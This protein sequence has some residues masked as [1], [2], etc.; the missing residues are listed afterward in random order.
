[1]KKLVISISIATALSSALNAQNQVDA[2]RY[3]QT[4]YGGTA[5]YVGMGGAFGALGADAS[6][7][8]SNPAGIGMY[9]KSELT[10]TPTL[11]NGS[12]STNYNGSS[13]KDNK[14]NF[15]FGNAAFIINVPKAK[16]DGN[17]EWKSF[18]FGIAYNRQ[19]NFHNRNFISGNA[20]GSSLLN[21][22]V[23]ESDGNNPNNLNQFGNDLAYQTYLID[24]IP[25]EN[26]LYFSNTNF[27]KSSHKKS[28]ET[29]GSMGET[30]LA[31]GANYNNK[32][33]LGASL[34]FTKIKYEEISRY[35]ESDNDT[36]KTGTYLPLYKMDLT[37]FIVDENITT[38][39]RGVNFKV[40]A[41]YSF[42]DWI[43]IGAAVHSPTF[44]YDITDTY[45]DSI[46][47]I[48]KHFETPD[49]Y[50]PNGKT[51]TYS[52][53]EGLFDY[54]LT[55]PFRA[56][57]SI[58][59]IIK[60]MGL[61]SVDY[62]F[63]NYS[64]ARLNSSKDEFRDANKIIQSSY[65]SAS[66]IRV[67]TEWRFEPFSIRAGYAYYGSP[68]KSNLNDGS[69]STYSF[70]L[71]YKMEVFYLDVAYQLTQSKEKFYMYDA[72]FVNAS[73]NKIQSGAILTT[74]GFKF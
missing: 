26:N 67:G 60:K 58:G 12:T 57:A 29:S 65:T 5:R 55:S 17:A 14:F 2:L 74:V 70:G 66:N 6:T 19:N 56:V 4:I 27:S 61:I 69:R 28:I 10:F 51:N 47:A 32:L 64:Q 1:M 46:T 7:L 52:S 9:R 40:G 21:Q 48:Y 42:Y 33:Y 30:S 72:A 20:Q 71:G 43:R 23:A 13:N 50:A 22:F 38:R 35:E 3:S 24:T 45:S 41:V 44:F 37:K 62:E 73:D 59:F 63:V 53:P 16:N 18:S 8:S 25:G 68:Y 36:S 49:T 11:Y 31:F 34:G 39:G 15:N 54:S